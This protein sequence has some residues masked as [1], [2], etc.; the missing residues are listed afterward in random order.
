MKHVKEEKAIEFSWC[1]CA[2]THHLHPFLDLL[3]TLHEDDVY[4]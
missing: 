2:E 1:V 3:N 4:G